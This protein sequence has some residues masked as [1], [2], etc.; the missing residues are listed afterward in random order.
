[1]TKKGPRLPSPIATPS[2]RHT[3]APE[4]RP[5]SINTKDCHERSLGLPKRNGQHHRRDAHRLFSSSRQG[6]RFRYSLLSGRGL[7][8]LGM[9]AGTFLFAAMTKDCATLRRCRLL[10]GWS[11]MA[12]TGAWVCSLGES[13]TRSAPDSANSS[14]EMLT[15][16]ADSRPPFAVNSR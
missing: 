5:R 10:S 1:M 8:V 3:A 14:V 12:S 4:R 15:A 2:Y 6:R 9:W 13:T 11:Y 16:A 7:G